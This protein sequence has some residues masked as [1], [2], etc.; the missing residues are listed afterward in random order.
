VHVYLNS[1]WAFGIGAGYAAG[2]ANDH[3]LAKH[4]VLL[5]WLIS[6]GPV[7]GFEVLPALQITGFPIQP[8]HKERVPHAFHCVKC[9]LT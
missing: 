1:G 3:G 9:T 5:P 7:N 2:R 6:S 4:V 8:P